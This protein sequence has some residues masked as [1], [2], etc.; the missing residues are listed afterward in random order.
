MLNI[1]TNRSANP[2]VEEEDFLAPL[3]AKTETKAKAGNS[4]PFHFAKAQRL[5]AKNGHGGKGVEMIFGKQPKL[6]FKSHPAKDRVETQALKAVSEALG[7]ETILSRSF[8]GGEITF[9][10]TYGD[11]NK[12]KF[13][14]EENSLK[15]LNGEQREKVERAI[16]KMSVNSPPQGGDLVTT[17]HTI[18]FSPLSR[19]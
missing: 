5:M 4:A 16:E 11:G 9:T 15:G 1:E 7:K 17:F 3:P 19:K 8:A 18:K 2:K 10:A 13:R 12:V 6:G 14:V